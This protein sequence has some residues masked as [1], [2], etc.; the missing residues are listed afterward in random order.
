MRDEALDG[1]VIM[2]ISLAIQQNASLADVSSLHGRYLMD[3][4][5]L[6]CDWF[7]YWD[8]YLRGRPLVDGSYVNLVN[9]GNVDSNQFKKKSL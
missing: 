8:Q 9:N 7:D 5:R 3:A 4:A 6:Y 2:I 1:G